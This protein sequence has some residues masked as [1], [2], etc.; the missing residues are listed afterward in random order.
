MEERVYI[1]HPFD[2]NEA[3]VQVLVRHIRVNRGMRC[4]VSRRKRNTG[5]IDPR[6][7]LAV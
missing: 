6:F 3:N 4:E 2:K 1:E 5:T 7:I